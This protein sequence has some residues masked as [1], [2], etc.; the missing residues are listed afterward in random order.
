MGI[1]VKTVLHDSKNPDY[2]LMCVKR[3]GV[4]SFMARLGKT[5]ANKIAPVETGLQSLE[6]FVTGAGVGTV[7]FR[8]QTTAS[9]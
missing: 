8:L 7:F 1:I 3:N 4:V 2:N 5:S 9:Y 6:L